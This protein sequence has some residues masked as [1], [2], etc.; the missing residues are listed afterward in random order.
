MR[1]IN[2]LLISQ[3]TLTVGLT[4]LTFAPFG[5]T[6]YLFGVTSINLCQF[7]L[8]TCSYSVNIL[9]QA[10]IGCSLFAMQQNHEADNQQSK[11]EY[12]IFVIELSIT[13]CVTAVMGYY[14]K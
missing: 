11:T 14:A 5:L 12:L 10:F 7:L 6:S 2:E 9:M 4:R 1:A 8:G 3:G 13:V